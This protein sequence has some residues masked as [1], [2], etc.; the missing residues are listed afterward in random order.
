MKRGN[1]PSQPEPD[2]DF[3][4]LAGLHQQLE[5]VNRWLEGDAAV[6]NSIDDLYIRERL[7]EKRDKIEQNIQSIAV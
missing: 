1:R 2:S 6:E 3:T 5:Q 4:T 7:L